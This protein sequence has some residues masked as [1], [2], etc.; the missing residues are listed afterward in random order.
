MN[1][2][3]PNEKHLNGVV[4]ALFIALVLSGATATILV[5][6]FR[7]DLT[8]YSGLATDDEEAQSTEEFSWALLQADVFRPPRCSP[9]LLSAACGTGA[10]I[11]GTS[12]LTIVLSA[13]G[14]LS[15]ARRGSLLMT[16]ILIFVGM[17]VVAGYVTARLYK[18]FKGVR[19]LLA[20]ALT[21]L[22]FPGV[23]LCFFVLVNILAFN[24]GSTNN[25][26]FATMMVILVLFGISTSLVFVG[27]YFGNKRC[28]ME[29]PVETS[30]TQ[31]KIPRQPWFIGMPF[32]VTAS[33]VLP[34]GAYY[35]ELYYILTSVW[36]NQYYY[37]FGYLLVVFFILV[38]V[39]AESAVVFCYLQL[40]AENH[41]WWW[42]SF[43]AGGSSG[44]Y[45]F[46]Y[47]LI[48]FKHLEA[49]NFTASILYFGY[50]GLLS[51]GMSMMTGFIGVA[52][53]LW[54]NMKLYSS[55]KAE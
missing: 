40:R 32:M 26:P 21:A 39:C 27:A 20:A 17:G 22:G 41:Q 46:L 45:M 38:V 37:V 1:H 28:A 50:M 3:I 7:R 44:M 8:R 9:L 53:C 6:N 51:L 55:M 5:K 19:W 12:F 49:T 13:M 35:V 34:F 18:A 42:R 36:L 33:G 25:V 16:T 52:G 23:F 10:Q 54:F 43:L 24:E 4:Q 14:M 48:F 15:P 29:F 11:L 2:A 30:N 31:R 47:S